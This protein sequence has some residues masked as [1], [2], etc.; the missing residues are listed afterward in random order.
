MCRQTSLTLG[1]SQ[2]SEKAEQLIEGVLPIAYAPKAVEMDEGLLYG[3]L[4]HFHSL[5]TAV[6]LKR[7]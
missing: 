2:L 4:A 6:L 7:Y 1:P 3:L 5:A